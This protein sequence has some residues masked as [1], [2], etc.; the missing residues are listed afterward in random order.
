[1]SL[2]RRD[3]GGRYEFTTL[4]LGD[5]R[6]LF[7]FASPRGQLTDFPV[8]R[9]VF[10][11]LHSLAWSDMSFFSVRSR[12]GQPD[13]PY[14][15]KQIPVDLLMAVLVL[16]LVPEALAV[17]GFV[18]TLRR[19]ALRPLAIFCVVTL[20]AYFWWVIP[21]D[22][23]ALKTKY[24]L[25]LL[26][27]G[28]LFAVVGHGWVQRRVPVLGHVATILMVALVVLTHVYLYAFAVGRIG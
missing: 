2:G 22:S 28:V 16:G 3:I 15:Y 27:P 7:G 11:S 12:H 26:P 23:W 18:V 5:V 25:C 19:R 24:I 13:H 1:L 17:V 9:S 21:Q 8:Y 6:A 20:C 10:T 14:P 4:R